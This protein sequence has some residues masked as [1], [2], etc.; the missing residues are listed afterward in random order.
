M[1]HSGTLVYYICRK[2]IMT[3]PK[4]LS[5]ENEISSFGKYFDC[6]CRCILSAQFG[7]GKSFFLS[8]FE[9]S[10]SQE[11]DFITLYPTNY[12]VCENKDIFE[13]I[14]RDILIGLL[15]LDDSILKT[16]DK[17]RRKILHNAIYSN[18]DDLLQCLPDISVGV[19]NINSAQIIKAVRNIYHKYRLCHTND[20]N[21]LNEYLSE[22][23]SGKSP[24]YEFDPISQIIC[25]IIDKRKS[26]GKKA[27]LVIEDLDR[28]DP[29]NIFR[30]LNIF[31]AHIS[32]KD[33]IDNNFQN[34]FGFEK[35]IIVCDYLN[36]KNIYHH[37]YGINTDFSGYISKFSPNKK[38]SY[39]LRS[40]M[41]DYFSSIIDGYLHNMVVPTVLA[42]K[43]FNLDKPNGTHYKN[44]FRCLIE[45]LTHSV[46]LI[47][48]KQPYFTIKDRLDEHIYI[49][50]REPML[51]FMAICKQF[52]IDYG[53]LISG[54]E[55]VIKNHAPNA[56]Y[57]L[58]EIF[59]IRTYTKHIHFDGEHYYI[60][61]RNYMHMH[62]DCSA[63][64]V[65]VEN[66]IIHKIIYHDGIS[67]NMQIN[68]F[69]KVVETM[70][71]YDEYI[72]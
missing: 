22:F 35:I 45:Q 48:D 40:R 11:Y 10:R 63:I 38:Y 50:N 41:K 62:F 3:I 31:S 21:I 71:Q 24:I 52:G 5:L 13:N 33:S 72:Q 16:F 20:S 7:E 66:R 19:L 26:Q 68:D 61:T 42:E 32:T 28:I 23:E 17:S 30:I 59:I 27:V 67:Q 56:L 8:E 60:P 49:S 29:G 37:L 25:E 1:P 64:E 9:K 65:V 6:N 53:E 54:Y 55:T 51:I 44:N 57:Q 4:T 15:A 46:D 14:K 39:S 70:N 43:I 12:Q 2:N 36:I 69:E 58:T 18:R 47:S 34:K